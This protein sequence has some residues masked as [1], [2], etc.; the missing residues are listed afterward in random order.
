MR[1]C[2]FFLSSSERWTLAEMQ[3][4]A[5][6]WSTRVAVAER[7]LADANAR[8]EKEEKKLRDLIHVALSGV[9][10]DRAESSPAVSIRNELRCASVKPSSIPDSMNYESH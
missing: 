10:T 2:A 8:K 4:Q 1:Q 9:E 3:N 7:A 5:S 6:Y